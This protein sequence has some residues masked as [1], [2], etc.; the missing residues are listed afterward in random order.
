M[1]ALQIFK[2]GT[3]PSVL[4]FIH[5]WPD[6]AD[7]WSEQIE[8]FKSTHLCLSVTLPHFDGRVQALKANA[9]SWGYDFPELADMVAAAA[10]EELQKIGRPAK[11]TLVI[12]DWGSVVSVSYSVP[13]CELLSVLL[14]Y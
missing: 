7:L 5:G 10:S 4:V 2:E 9:K 13:R 11:F 8:F 1:D 14:H 12:H 6:T 3:G